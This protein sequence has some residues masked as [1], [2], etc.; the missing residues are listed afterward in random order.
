ME[1]G[2]PGRGLRDRFAELP[3]PRIERTKRLNSATRSPFHDALNRNLPCA[4]TEAMTR[5]RDRFSVER[6]NIATRQASQLVID[7][8]A[9]PLPASRSRP[10][11]L[12]MPLSEHVSSP[13]RTPRPGS[14]TGVYCPRRGSRAQRTVPPAG[15]CRSVRLQR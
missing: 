2:A 8:I 4:Y 10:R 3:D 6:P 12:D 7:G 15:R 11:I 5:L 9:A 14:R 1:E 13:S